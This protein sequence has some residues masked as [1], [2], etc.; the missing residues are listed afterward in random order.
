MNIPPTGS[1]APQGR[2]PSLDFAT[3]LVTTAPPPRI[4]FPEVVSGWVVGLFTDAGEAS[5]TFQ[6]RSRPDRCAQIGPAIDPERCES[7][8]ARRART[9]VRRFMVANGLHRMGS[10][11]YAGEGL[12]DEHVIRRHVGHFFKRLRYEVV[13]QRFAYLWVPEWHPGGHGLHIH[14]AL[15]RF[16]KQPVLV[17]KWSHGILDIRR[18]NVTQHDGDRGAARRAAA[19]MAPYLAKDF[20]E[21]AHTHG[22]HRYEVAQ[23]FQPKVERIVA[24]T[25]AEAIRKA[26]ERMGAFPSRQWSSTESVGW[27][28][29]PAL[30]AQWR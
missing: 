28:G 27:S 8:A 1:G 24:T 4:A 25:R 12:T 10:A 18:F 26:S 13:G 6:Y 19:Y 29:P 23:G 7:E 2:R 9:M 3:K 14:F 16:I 17:E 30:W 5:G 20:N 11:T 15:D 22:L 21:H